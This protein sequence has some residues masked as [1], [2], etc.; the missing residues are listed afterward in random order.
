MR[1]RL[2]LQRFVEQPDATIGLL[3]A[4][5]IGAPHLQWWILEDQA[6]PGGVKVPGETRIP[7]G[8][9]PIRL[10]EAGRLYSTYRR[11][12]TWHRGMLELQGVPGFSCI[13]VHPGNDDDDTRG[14]LLPGLTAEIRPPR[15]LHSRTAY[16]QLYRAALAPAAQGALDIAVYDPPRIITGVEAKA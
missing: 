8:I 3:S 12:W 4:D 6:Q 7:A 16:E 10:Y 14:C 2:N 9:Y 1:M 13:L 11:R 5:S 15:V